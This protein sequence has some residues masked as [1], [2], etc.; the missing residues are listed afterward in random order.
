MLAYLVHSGVQHEISDNCFVFCGNQS[1][2]K[3]KFQ[4]VC[5]QVIM[6]LSGN[7]MVIGENRTMDFTFLSPTTKT[8]STSIVWKN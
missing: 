2:K 1:V 6:N 5:C 7:E 3:M 8:V 4:Q